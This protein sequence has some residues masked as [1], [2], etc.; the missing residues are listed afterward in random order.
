MVSTKTKFLSYK[1]L[2]YLSENQLLV[3]ENHPDYRFN[4]I[5]WSEIKNRRNTL[6]F[7]SAKKSS[8]DVNC[9][10]TSTIHILLAEIYLKD[11]S[12][13]SV[14][15]MLERSLPAINSFR[16]GNG[17][18]FFPLMEVPKKLVR[19]GEADLYPAGIRRA[20]HFQYSRR[21]I[22]HGF[23]VYNDADD[24]ASGIYANF[25]SHRIDPGQYPQNITDPDS[26]AAFFAEYRDVPGSRTN[27]WNWLRGHGTKTGAYNTWFPDDQ[28]PKAHTIFPHKGK[29]YIP[30][31]INDIDCVL[32]TNVLGILAAIGAK[33]TPEMHEAANWILEMIRTE[34]CRSCAVYYPT[35]YS[36]GYA[37]VKACLRGATL[38]EPAIEP[39]LNKLILEQNSD[40]SWS[41]SM[42]ENEVLTTLHAVNS[43]IGIRSFVDEDLDPVISSG[44]NYVLSKVHQNKNLAWLDGGVVFS[45]GSAFKRIHVWVSKAY[46]TALLLEALVIR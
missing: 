31:G 14:P 20:S 26:V 23:N 16:N 17:Y 2:N 30:F 32:N 36:L 8:R 40:G 10:V 11:S 43:L 3:P 45:C 6:L 1:L 9:F 27:L 29:Y 22:L 38:L 4:G 12:L 7:G 37:V 5:W 35:G 18:N 24:T 15:I 41:D 25:M 13:E 21:F 28:D 19:K 46:T 34:K 42:K 44:L 33:E 39:I